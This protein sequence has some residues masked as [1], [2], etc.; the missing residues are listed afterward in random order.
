MPAGEIGLTP[1]EGDRLR[2]YLLKG[3]FLWVDDFWGTAAWEHW[4]AEI[5][6]VLPSG[7]SSTRSRMWPPATRFSG[8]YF[9]VA[10]M[11]QITNIQFWRAVGGTTTSERGA[12]SEET[13]F[14]VIRDAG[15]PDR[16]RDDAQHRYR[17]LM[18]TG[19]REPPSP[20]VLTCCGYAFEES[21]VILHALRH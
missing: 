17:G 3:G 16:R 5:G 4:A 18:G 15:G 2:Q 6:K 1:Q 11:P 12:D 21:N 13:H 8:V 14:R 7:G 20:P 10:R 19:R 9:N